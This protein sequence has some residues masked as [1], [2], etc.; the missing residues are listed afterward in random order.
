MGISVWE[1]VWDRNKAIDMEQ[2]SICGGGRLERFYCIVKVG[3]YLLF[4]I[5]NQIQDTN[6]KHANLNYYKKLNSRDWNQIE[7][8]LPS[9]EDKC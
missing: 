3:F 7:R 2:W 9:R 1:M 4:A 8:A 6:K 5:Y